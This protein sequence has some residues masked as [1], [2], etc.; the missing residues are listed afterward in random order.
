[1]IN[2]GVCGEEII[3][4]KSAIDKHY[5]ELHRFSVSEDDTAFFE[6]AVI[7]NELSCDADLDFISDDSFSGGEGGSSGGGGADG[8]W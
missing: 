7:M 8:S 2:C 3:G 6:S 1:M 4:V 5:K